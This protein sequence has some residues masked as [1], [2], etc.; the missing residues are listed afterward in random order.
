MALEDN[1]ARLEGDGVQFVDGG[2]EDEHW[3]RTARSAYE[4]STTWFD[5]SVRQEIEKN[6]ARFYSQHPPGS[7]YNTPDYEKRSK[8]FRPKT[9]AAIRHNEAAA[10][11]AAFATD[12]VVH[13]SAPNKSDPVQRLAARLHKN[14]INYRL[15]NSIPWFT[16]FN[17][18]V[19]E[20][21]VTGVVCSKQT[22]EFRERRIVEEVRRRDVVTGEIF[23]HNEIRYEV[24]KDRPMIELRPVELVRFDSSCDWTDPVNSSP[25]I[26]D[27]I[28]MYVKDVKA[29]M[30]QNRDDGKGSGP[31]FRNLPDSVLTAAAA[32][33]WDSIRHARE[34]GR[35]D[36]YENDQNLHD[37]MTVWVYEVT[38]EEEDGDWV[39]YTLGNVAMLSD[40][41]PIEEV[42]LHGRPFSFG[43]AIIEAHKLYPSAVPQLIDGLQEMANDVAN[44]RLDA[45]RFAMAGR[46]FVAR[47]RGVD[48]RTLVRHVPG[49]A[50][51]MNDPSRDVRWETPRANV[52]SAYEEQDRLNMDM[53]DI[54]GT[55]SQGSQLQGQKS[56][57]QQTVGGAEILQGPSAQLQEYLIRTICETWAE[58]A[59]KQVLLLESQYETDENV[60]Q[61]AADDAGVDVQTAFRMLPMKVDLSI[62]I[63]FGATSPLKRIERFALGMR[64]MAEFAPDMVMQADRKEIS[65][66]VFGALGMDGS[67]FFPSLR[68][69]EQQDPRVAQLQQENDML[70]QAIETKQLERATRLEV[71]QITHQGKMAGMQLDWA[72]FNR[73]L[74]LDAKLASIK[75]ALNQEIS[76]V[77]SMLKIEKADIERRQLLLQREALNKAILDSERE[78]QITL[79]QLGLEGPPGLLNPPP[80]DQIEGNIPDG[81]MGEGAVDLPGDDLAGTISRDDYGDV[82]FAAQ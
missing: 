16:I 69:G 29:R 8:I 44:L 25:Y 10:A 48:I 74:Q 6:Y 49:S 31:T 19:Q 17:A 14:V 30:K 75:E 71:A 7:K 53:D 60:L 34:Q 55:M 33:D 24:H 18:A 68:S 35:L 64:T 47:G 22:W 56:R 39:Y 50:V 80:V 46:Y 1:T 63:G 41:I 67:R 38:V 70:R 62:N 3:L 37:F 40:P 54:T 9:R 61:I 12:D 23:S 78:Y 81:E 79:Y 57:L 28:P 58:P 26:I 4:S 59:L 36:R 15:R 42:Y 51:M 2:P 13:C 20:A 5:S 52:Q 11:V 72:K 76:R 82:P 77:D 65:L 66:E 45:S 43:S 32:Q 73:K 27:M 21:Q